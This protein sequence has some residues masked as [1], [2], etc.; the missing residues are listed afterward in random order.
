M[1]TVSPLSRIIVQIKNARQEAGVSSSALAKASGIS[2]S[3]MSK[4][5]KGR[6]NPSYKLIYDVTEALAFSLIS[7]QP[8]IQIKDKMTKNVKSLS[9]SSRISEAKKIMR[10][11]GF[12]QVPILDRHGGPSGLVTERSLL[13]HPDAMTCNEALEFSFAVIE[14]Y[15]SFER[16][17]RIARNV[18]ALLIVKDGKLVGILT[19]AD[20]I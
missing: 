7:K 13:E 20:F 2:P 19:K 17:R 5:E 18:Q 10:D 4:L 6:L 11:N 1:D 9:L 16:A 3:A 8:L 15:F 12:S 14:S